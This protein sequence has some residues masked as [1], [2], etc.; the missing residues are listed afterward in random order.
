MYQYSLH[1]FLDIF[2]SVLYNNARL[3]DV[4]DHSQRLSIVTSDLFQVVYCRVARGML[5]VD[6]LTFAIL[7]CRIHVHG[8]ATEPHLDAEFQHFLRGKDAFVSHHAA[9]PSL[10]LDSLGLASEEMEALTRLSTR[11]PVFKGLLK[12]I[13]ESADQFRT[14]LTH[15]TP[16]MCVPTLWH[17]SD[18]S[19]IGQVRPSCGATFGAIDESSDY[20]VV[21]LFSRP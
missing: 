16:E 20:R 7:L 18:L 6:R 8:L 3:K 2:H 10:E 12:R 4:S 13:N 15:Q 1:F 21:A 17:N 9:P 5:H 11:L 19:P 14:W